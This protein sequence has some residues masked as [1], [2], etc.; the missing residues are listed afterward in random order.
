MTRSAC[1][2]AFSEFFK[3]FI[4]WGDEETFLPENLFTRTLPPLYFIAAEKSSRPS[5]IFP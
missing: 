3:R 5:D 1:P 2:Y 4:A